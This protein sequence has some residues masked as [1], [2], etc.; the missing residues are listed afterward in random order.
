MALLLTESAD[1][2]NTE[3][4][5]GA[6]FFVGAGISLLILS[7]ERCKGN[8]LLTIAGLVIGC[9]AF[10]A[11]SVYFAF[12]WS[13][14]A[15]IMLKLVGW[16][17]ILLFGLCGTWKIAGFVRDLASRKPRVVVDEEGLIVRGERVKWDNVLHVKRDN[18]QWVIVTD[19]CEERIAH[20]KVPKRWVMWL[21][22]RFYRATVFVP[23]LEYRGSEADFAKQ[24]QHFRNLHAANKKPNE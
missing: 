21:N 23:Y 14:R 9:A 2:D 24:C 17:G 13:D 12:F 11:V 10:T 1:K 5:I 18:Y 7:S 22:Y 16:I 6:T 3:D 19:D 15:N 20:A 4:W 8:W